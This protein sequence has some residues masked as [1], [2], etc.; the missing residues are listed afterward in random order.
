MSKTPLMA[1]HR[2]N[3]KLLLNGAFISALLVLLLNDH[4]WKWT[5]ANSF[6]GK[7]SDV[8]GLVLLPLLLTYLFPRLRVNSIWISTLFFILWKTPLVTPL[9]ESYN[10]WALIPISRVVDYTDY[11]ALLILPLPYWLLY[12]SEQQAHRS[13]APR[14]KRYHW[15]PLFAW[16]IG[17]IAALAFMATS[18]PRWYYFQQ[19]SGNVR[20]HDCRYKTGKTADE[21]LQMLAEE[22]I[23]AEL[24]TAFAQRTYVRYWEANDSNSVQLPP[25][26]RIP[27]LVVAEDTLRDIQ[28]ALMPAAEGEVMFLLNG[29]Q[30]DSLETEQ[31]DQKLRRMYRKLLKKNVV[32]KVR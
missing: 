12:R 1:Q 26:Y 14:E 32:R 15:R 5:H 6:T 31:V 20:F 25:F 24:D 28:F 2:R 8:S 27:Q 22:G 30:V 21:I 18:P 10:H 4:L 9:I 16:S 11:W 13:L 23:S 17:L 3:P 29:L 19:S 7:L